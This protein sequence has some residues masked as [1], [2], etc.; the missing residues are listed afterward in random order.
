MKK[1][2]LATTI[3]IQTALC[4]Q[5]PQEIKTPAQIQAELDQAQRDFE[6]AKKM[7]I[8][9]YT[10]PLITSSASNVPPGNWVI[11]PYLFLLL[12]YAQ[13]DDN[14]KSVNITDIWTIEPLF[15]LQTGI[16]D[17]LDI[18]GIAE[19]IFRWQGNQKAQEVGDTSITFGIQLLKQAPY[20]P[21]LR[22][23]I[24]ESFPTGRY[25]KLDPEKGGID[26]SGSGA[27]AT[28]VGMNFNKIYW[29]IPLHPVS[30]RLVAN[31]SI[32]NHQVEV[33]N[34]NAYGGGFNAK[35]D[36]CVGQTF[37]ADLGVE[38]SLTQQWVFA[39]DL[40]YTVSRETSFK[41]NPGLTPLG[42]PASVGGPISDQFSIA[43]AIEYN[44]SEKG[45][46]IGGVWFTATGRNSTNFVG[47]ILSFTWLF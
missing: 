25:Q 38:V 29:D 17:W 8:P 12:D 30:L 15:L 4:A 31:Y 2:L 22:L 1:T 45:G 10:G 24:G 6:T 20:V 9:W 47:L 46:F 28:V 44:I 42:I 32:P 23:T 16:T 19:G 35:G 39:I 18:T 3:A 36:V 27:F 37:N 5:E 13:Y 7:F 11:Q 14:R 21:S 41:G 40:A 26:A 43:P 34:F 33:K